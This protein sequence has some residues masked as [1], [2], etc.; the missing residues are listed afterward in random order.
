MGGVDATV[1]V[2]DA[3]NAAAL[4]CAITKMHGTVIQIAQVSPTTRLK[5]SGGS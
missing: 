2:S 5:Q 1:N 4:S 3:E